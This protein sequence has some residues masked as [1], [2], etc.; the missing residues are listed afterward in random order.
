MYYLCLSYGPC[1]SGS[2]CH[3]GFAYYYASS[4]QY[5]HSFSQVMTTVLTTVTHP[6]LRSTADSSPT[7]GV[8]VLAPTAAP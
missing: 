4:S 3:V 6:V 2:T 8:A 7:F 1:A 5:H